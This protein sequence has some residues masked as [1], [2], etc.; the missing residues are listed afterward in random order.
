VSRALSDL[1]PRFR[2]LAYEF[3]AKLVE[4]GIHVLIV[5]TLR[6]PEEQAENIRRGVSW[7]PHSRHLT[8][9]AIDVCPYEVFALSGPD[10]LQWDPAHPV[11]TRIGRVAESCGLVWGG[12]WAQRDLGH[13]EAPWPRESGITV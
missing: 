5:D 7:T 9:D 6:T 12:R 13:V 11:W 10:K 2:P 3:L 8:G 4:S 1:S